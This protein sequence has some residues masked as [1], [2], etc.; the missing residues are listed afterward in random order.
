[1]L[2]RRNNNAEKVKIYP[3]AKNAVQMGESVTMVTFHRPE[4]NYI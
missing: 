2:W 4:T 1:M 3:G